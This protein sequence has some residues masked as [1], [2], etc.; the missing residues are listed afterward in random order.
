MSLSSK[1]KSKNIKKNKLI[2]SRS[3]S[4]N[5]SLKKGTIIS[6]KD[7]ILKK[8]GTEIPFE[9]KNEIIGKKLLKNKSKDY[10][11]KKSDLSK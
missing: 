3:W 9:K 1:I 2:F 4:L 6:E 10:L 5:K 8:P 7:L 11:L